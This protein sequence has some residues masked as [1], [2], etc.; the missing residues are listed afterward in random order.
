MVARGERMEVKLF[1]AR[2]PFTYQSYVKYSSAPPTL[3]PATIR[4]SVLVCARAGENIAAYVSISL[5]LLRNT[6]VFRWRLFLL[7]FS[8]S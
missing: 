5:R 3:H 2:L 8:L 6:S 1:W 7:Y 4:V